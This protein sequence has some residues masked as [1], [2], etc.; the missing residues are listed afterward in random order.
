MFRTSGTVSFGPDFT[1][2]GKI[3]TTTTTRGSVPFET[4]LKERM[5]NWGKKKKRG[6]EVGGRGEVFEVSE[7]VLEVG[8]ASP[9]CRHM[10]I[11]LY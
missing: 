1:I 9:D 4:V 2:I 6:S 11:E 10:R 3:V 5:V 8:L 7:V